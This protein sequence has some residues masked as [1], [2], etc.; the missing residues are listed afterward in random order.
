MTVVIDASAVVALLLRG[1]QGSLVA[2]HLRGDEDL[3]WTL[4]LVDAEVGQAL[5]GMVMRRELPANRA[6][7]ALKRLAAMPLRRTGMVSMLPE[8]W[9]LRN[10]LS[11]YDALYVSLAAKL[12]APLLT[13]DR[14][15][16][17][18]PKLPARVIVPA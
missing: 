10:N 14:R 7:G 15:M 5:R 12:E 16:A 3:P 8:A 9:T 13:F 18:A 1:T 4:P 2:E 17:G 11:F 6:S